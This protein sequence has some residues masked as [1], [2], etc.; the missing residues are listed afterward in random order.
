MLGLCF[1]FFSLELCS[2]VARP[3]QLYLPFGS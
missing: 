3:Y 2:E 1:F